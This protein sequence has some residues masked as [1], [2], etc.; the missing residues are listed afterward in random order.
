MIVVVGGVN[1][2]TLWGGGWGVRLG[3]V[4]VLVEMLHYTQ[5]SQVTNI[6]HNNYPA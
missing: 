4:L 5:M 3:V 1:V 6:I 2:V